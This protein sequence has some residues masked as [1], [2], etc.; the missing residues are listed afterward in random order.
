MSIRLIAAVLAFA[1]LSH[2][3][4]AGLDELPDYHRSVVSL[5]LP[6][7]SSEVCSP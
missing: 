4:S 2:Q 7:P 1:S 3:A 5:V 6:E